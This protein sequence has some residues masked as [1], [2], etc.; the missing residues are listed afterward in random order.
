[1]KKYMS[2]L[3]YFRIE[4]RKSCVNAKGMPAAPHNRPDS[5]QVCVCVGGG[6]PQSW[7]EGRITPVLAG[8]GGGAGV[9]LFWLKVGGTPVLVWGT[10]QKLYGT[11]YRGIN[12]N[13]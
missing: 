2:R 12:W 4:T 6:L 5:V 1:M 7:L 10:T 3:H 8:G 9:P 13:A 11:R